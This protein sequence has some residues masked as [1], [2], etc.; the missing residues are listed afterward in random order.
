[1]LSA[2]Y[3][4]A[5]SLRISSLLFLHSFQN[6]EIKAHLSTISFI[7]KDTKQIDPKQ[8]TWTAKYKQKVL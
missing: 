7:H 6:L 3:L 5:N 1:M 8:Y 2:A 4:V